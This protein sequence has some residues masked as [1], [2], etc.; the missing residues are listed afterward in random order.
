MAMRYRF[1]LPGFDR[2]GL[3]ALPL[4]GVNQSDEGNMDVARFIAHLGR[5]GMSAIRLT[6]AAD[7]HA[8]LDTLE[9]WLQ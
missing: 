6:A 3:S 5:L 2:S 9:H 7:T 1:K 4:A 8:D